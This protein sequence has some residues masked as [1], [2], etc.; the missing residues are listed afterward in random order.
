MLGH[1]GNIYEAT[2]IESQTLGNLALAGDRLEALHEELR[3]T[4]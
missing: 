4:A 2:L 1:D 3:G